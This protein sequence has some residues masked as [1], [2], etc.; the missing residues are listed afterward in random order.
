[1][2]GPP[3]TAAGMRLALFADVHGNPLALDAVLADVRGQ[4]GVDGYLVLG[5]LAAG[6]YDPSGAV[7][8]LRALPNARFVRGN[9]EASLAQGEPGPSLPELRRKP[10]EAARLIELA[11]LFAW[12]HGHLVARG[13]L[14]WIAALPLELRLTLPDGTRVLGNHA[15]PGSD[16]TDGL[17]LR[18]SQSDDD[19]RALLAGC[20][21]DVVCA[22]HT[23]WPMDRTVDGVR[24]LNVGSVSN[25]WAPDLRAC[26]TLLQ[27]DEHG[28]RAEQ[29]RVAYDLAAVLDALRRAGHPTAD[30]LAAHFR[31]ERTAPWRRA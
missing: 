15:A 24:I 18:P 6:G 8:R 9:T 27:A 10:E 31:G 21:A 2:A 23:H 22:G 29:R 7:E 26:W 28:Y 16:G 25:P 12:A 1:M 13:H 5:D 30:T 20:D 3:Y 11:A 17:A 19:L 14:D 4:G